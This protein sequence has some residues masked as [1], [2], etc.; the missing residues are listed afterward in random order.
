MLAIF[1]GLSTA[2]VVAAGPVRAQYETRAQTKARLMHQIMYDDWDPYSSDMSIEEFYALME[3]FDEGKL[4]LEKDKNNGTNNNRPGQLTPGQST[5]NQSTPSWGDG[6]SIDEPFFDGQEGGST[7]T[8]STKG[9]DLYIPRSM[10]M[11]TG[12]PDSFVAK[13][14][15]DQNVFLKYKSEFIE[16]DSEPKQPW[17]NN[18]GNYVEKILPYGEKEEGATV[19]KDYNYEPYDPYTNKSYTVK[20][21]THNDNGEVTA[22]EFTLDGD[23]YIFNAEDGRLYN[24]ICKDTIKAY[25]FA[26][27]HIESN[28]NL[29]EF[30]TRNADGG[31]LYNSTG[32]PYQPSDDPKENR[33]KSLSTENVYIVEKSGEGLWEYDENNVAGDYLG[34]VFSEDAGD[35]FVYTQMINGAL[36]GQ[37]YEWKNNALYIPGF[38]TAQT[39]IIKALA[40]YYPSGLDRYGDG[41]YRPAMDWKGVKVDNEDK[42]SDTYHRALIVQEGKNADDRTIAG[43]VDQSFFQ[44]YEGYYV[45]Q[46]SLGGIEAKVLGII[47]IEEGKYVYYYLS[48]EDQSNTVSTT[49]LNDKQRFIV[50]YTVN[51][52]LVNYAVAMAGEDVKTVSENIKKE[53]NGKVIYNDYVTDKAKKEAGF[54]DVASIFGEGRPSNTTDGAYSFDVTAPY[55]Y[56][57]TI[58][59]R[60]D[61]TVD[62]TPEKWPEGWPKTIPIIINHTGKRKEAEKDYREAFEKFLATVDSSFNIG[63]DID[64]FVYETGSGDNR[65]LKLTY[66]GSSQYKDVIQGVLDK[67]AERINEFSEHNDAHPLGMYPVYEL[68]GDALTPNTEEGPSV[69]N[70]NETFYNHN[71]RADR[72]IIAVLTKLH[73]PQF[74]VKEMLKTSNLSGRGTSSTEKF[75][76]NSVKPY[77]ELEG[78]EGDYYDAD[79]IWHDDD[80]AHGGIKSEPMTGHADY[81]NIETGDGWKWSNTDYNKYDNLFHS[82]KDMW[83]DDKDGLYDFVWVF[84]TNNDSGGYLLDSLSINGVA[85]EVPF[86]PKYVYR[87]R[88]NSYRDTTYTFANA[89]TNNE[90]EPWQTK[91]TLPDGATVY[92]EK[93]MGA[94]HF[95][96]NGHPQRVYRIRV[97]GARADVTITSMN[98]MQG[99][100]A[101][102]FSV[103]NLEGIYADQDDGTVNQN[104]GGIQF[105]RNGN[106]IWQSQA[107][108]VVETGD[109]WSGGTNFFTGDTNSNDND[110]VNHYGANIRFKIADGYGDPYFIWQSTKDGVIGTQTSIEYETDDS[111]NPI[112]KDGKLKLLK[113]ANGDY[114]YNPVISLKDATTDGYTGEGALTGGKLSS[115]YIYKDD[116]GWYYIRM[117]NQRTPDGKTTYKIAL[118]TIIARTQKYVVRY[119]PG[120]IPATFDQRNNELIVAHGP[121]DMPEFVHIKG[122]KLWNMAATID[123]ESGELV[124][125]KASEAILPQYDN[126]NGIFYDL[127]NNKI[128]TLTGGSPTDPYNLYR[129]VRWVIVDENFVPIRI[130]A[131]GKIIGYDID[132]RWKFNGK[133][134]IIPVK[135]KCD[136]NGKLILDENNKPI[137]IMHRLENGNIVYYEINNGIETIGVDGAYNYHEEGTEIYFTGGAIDL[138]L[139][140]QYAVQHASFHTAGQDLYVLRLMPVWERIEHPYFYNVALNWLDAQGNIHTENFQGNWKTVLTE[141]PSE[142]ELYVFINKDAEPL[143]DWIAQNPTYTFW[144]ALNNAMTNDDIKKAFDDY[145][146]ANKIEKDSIPYDGILDALQC[147]DFTGNYTDKDGN[148]KNSEPGYWVEDKQDITKSYYHHGGNGQDDFR[149]LGSKDTFAVL[150]D[151]ATIII[152]M[153]EKLGGFIFHKEVAEEPLIPDDEFY[154]TVVDAKNVVK[155]AKGE[156][157]NA[158]GEPAGNKEDYQYESLDGTY[159]AYPQ[160]DY[161]DDENNNKYI[162]DPTGDVWYVH[163]DNKI[164]KEENENLVLVRPIVNSDAMLVTFKSGVISQIEQN[165]IV[166]LDENHEKVTYF[167]LKHGDGIEIYVPDGMYTIVELGSKSGG[168]YRADV[169]YTA[170]NLT[171]G[172]EWTLPDN[173]YIPNGDP[174]DKDGEELWVIGSEKKYISLQPGEKYNEGD[175]KD[176]S[177]IAAT[178][179][180]DIGAAN[181]VTILTFK[182]MTISISIEKS[183]DMIEDDE[184]NKLIPDAYYET[185]FTIKVTLRLIEGM[186]PIEEE[187][188]GENGQKTKTGKY[189]FQVNRYILTQVTNDKTNRTEEVVLPAEEGPTIFYFKQ[190][191]VKENKWETTFKIKAKERFIIVM[192]AMHKEVNYWIDELD[193]TEDNITNITGYVHAKLGTDEKGNVKYE[194]TYYLTLEEAKAA[195]PNIEPKNVFEK[196]YDDS[197]KSLDE[198]IQPATLTKMDLTPLISPDF[199]KAEVGKKEVVDVV[200]W[201][202]ELPGYG[203]LA[204]TVKGDSIRS[205][206]SFIFRIVSSKDKSGI[207][208]SVKGGATVYIYLPCGTYSIELT[209]WSWRYD[210]N[211]ATVI[212]PSKEKQAGDQGKL[213]KLSVRVTNKH[214]LRKNAIKAEFTYNPN[215]KGWVGGEVGNAWD[216]NSAQATNK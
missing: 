1:W 63:D 25:P 4:P 73:D 167:T 177:Q 131:N 42:T 119:Y 85:F 41:Y 175:Y 205:S 69:F 109:A 47:E 53:V 65:D 35:Y 28:G 23:T 18:Y 113:D 40:F 159:K 168:A 76:K 200:N 84:Q 50:Q 110:G 188:D 132:D 32:E 88:T 210:Q 176:K 83:D 162:S 72:I 181:V 160:P 108:I 165:G 92:V 151:N 56:T 213:D 100:G 121:I 138:S 36:T 199:G 11:Y 186:T 19:K 211:N 127:L 59:I 16:R 6:P 122:S 203:Y 43:D 104:V 147:L 152:W 216:N 172:E 82:P 120:I 34:S 136:K 114:L 189:Y 207:T 46:V 12:L 150:E 142:G 174:D 9:E 143:N 116:D 15:T 128:A 97:V 30:Y 155:N 74:S 206:D 70:W 148:V 171:S 94:D 198:Y 3:L 90:T 195:A 86:Y 105:Y 190:I 196:P 87:N 101:D 91:G 112:L 102:E 37:I 153:Y 209:D 52:H 55:G 22:G 145:I 29:G 137:P 77:T 99:T 178:V 80:N 134:V 194:Y 204:I 78:F 129:F 146:V 14:P 66:K 8:P 7:T 33:F 54:D 124:L 13:D 107:Q 215:N 44:K 48:A 62:N 214:K 58:Y 125:S 123:E 98:L 141:A 173:W 103:F 89:S 212:D 75:A 179:D 111:G 61:M 21:I 45:K 27:R 31:K 38:E 126:N 10:F 130:N 184:G 161:Y 135:Y 57:T 79:F 17:P 202:G 71:V 164:T 2:V 39:N 191:D 156:P 5:P 193:N 183:L 117:D 197:D 26:F 170:E 20:S 95:A 106:W 68:D 201:F 169:V 144:D 60:L 49:T 67:M 133:T 93:L 163:G 140:S 192:T 158:K 96:G 115:Q 81:P 208:V 149:R 51:E 24:E 118:L 154:F 139:Y 157:V 166:W 182:N 64:D 180:F 185:V 187:I